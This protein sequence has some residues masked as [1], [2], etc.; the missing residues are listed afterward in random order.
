MSNRK[1]RL[2]LPSKGALG[3]PTLDLLASIGLKV[4]RPNDRQYVASI[5]ALSQVEVLFQRAADIYTKVYEG[6]VDLGITGYD[7]VSEEDRGGNSV[8]T[9]A[10]QLGYG[11]CK[12]VLAVPDSWIDV[13][14]IEDL[15]ELTLL[16]K[17]QGKRLRIATGY[18]NVT[19]KWLFDRRITHFSLVDAKGA[20]EAAPS[21]G[22]ADMIADITSTGTTLRENRLKIVRGGTMLSS[23]A[24]LIANRRALQQ[25][26]TLQVAELILELIE[27]R[28]NAKQYTSIT[29]NV[30]GQSLEEVGDR[31]TK[32]SNLTGLTGLRGPTIAKVYCEDASD[33]AASWYAATIVVKQGDM[34]SA[35]AHLRQVGGTDITVTPP[36]FIFDSHSAS[37][38]ALSHKLAKSPNL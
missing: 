15:A 29:A 10:E 16:W 25:P 38:Q 26:D 5:P 6:T 31:L 35:V 3:T 21:M 27:A 9:A 36:T 23:E 30:R 7:V 28:R 14:D 11:P 33:S 12:L 19:K 34:L 18:K 13:T 24:C 1:V 32:Q 22:Y 2:A 4:Y 8:I 37:S 17:E 20:L